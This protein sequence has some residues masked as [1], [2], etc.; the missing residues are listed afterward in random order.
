[1]AQLGAIAAAVDRYLLDQGRL[2]A[3]LDDLTQPPQGRRLPYL[4]SIPED[5]WNRAFGLR[6]IDARK[7]EIRS[8]GAD[9]EMNTADDVVWPKKE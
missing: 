5:P 2:P 3:T 4:D 8:A 7:Y 9:G 1:M 6:A